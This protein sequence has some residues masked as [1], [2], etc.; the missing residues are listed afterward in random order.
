MSGQRR[1]KWELRAI[2]QSFCEEIAGELRFDN[3]R[4]WALM[5][6]V[7]W[8]C[9]EP[10]RISVAAL[11]RLERALETFAAEVDAADERRL[12]ATNTTTK[13]ER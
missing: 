12:R 2:V 10:A 8:R 1:T 3:P 6:R 7:M 5:P 9:P 4:D 11:R 13:E